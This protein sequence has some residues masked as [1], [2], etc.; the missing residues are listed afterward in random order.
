ML[1][2]V[3]L[4]AWRGGR[5][6]KF[7]CNA[8]VV[9]WLL[10]KLLHKYKGL[11]PEWGILVVDIGLMGVLLWLALRSRRHWPLFAAGFHLLAV[12]THVARMADPTVGGWAYLTAAIIWGY[13]VVFSVA[14][15]AWTAPRRG[16]ANAPADAGATRR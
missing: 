5:E 9:A 12:V 1:A 10:S 4:V 8:L 16:Q 15:G 11:Q 6:E 7:A 2:L 13:L 3:A 14:Y